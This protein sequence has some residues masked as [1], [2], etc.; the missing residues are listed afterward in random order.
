LIRLERCFI[1]RLFGRIGA[2][3]LCRAG[4]RRRRNDL[5]LLGREGDAQP[6]TGLVVGPLVPPHPAAA[7]Q[8][9]DRDDARDERV[10]IA[11]GL[12]GL[13]D[14]RGP[15]DELVL[16]EVVTFSRLHRDSSARHRTTTGPELHPNADFQQRAQTF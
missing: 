13:D 10:A 1:A 15:L 12:E 5:R 3:C 4:K 7:N 16:L 11:I 14:P 8:Q 6:G 9:H 2:G